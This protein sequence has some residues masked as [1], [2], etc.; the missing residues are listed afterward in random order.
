MTINYEIINNIVECDYKEDNNHD[1][2]LQWML[3]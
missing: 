2:P 3:A 1:R